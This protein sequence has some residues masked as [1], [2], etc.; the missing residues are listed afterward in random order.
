[1]ARKSRKTEIKEKQE[2]RLTSQKK[3][4]CL[5][6]AAYGRLS[7]YNSGHDT[8]DTIQNQTA[9]LVDYIENQPDLK[10]E[11]VYI[12]NGYS[13]TNFERPEFA[14]LMDDVRTGKIQCIVVKD[15]SR[16]GRNYLEMGYY[17]ETLLPR[18]NVRLIAITDDF[19]SSRA[20]DRESISVPIKNMVNAMYAKDLSRKVGTAAIMRRQNPDKLPNGTA[21]FGYLMNE[22]KTQYILHPEIAPYVR[23]IF[24]WYLLG[25]RPTEIAKRMTLLGVV[26]PVQYRDAQGN[27]ENLKPKKWD[28]SCVQHLLEQP[29]FVGDLFMGKFHAALYKNEAARKLPREEWTVRKN[30]HEPL[31]TRVDYE[32]VR[33]NRANHYSQIGKN[34]EVNQRERQ[35]L[36]P[37]LPAIVYCAECNRKMV[38]GRYMHDYASKEKAVTYY[39]CPRKN[40]KAKCGGH[41]VFNDFLKVVVMD[42]IRFMVQGVCNRK[43]LI[44]KISESGTG[45]NQLLSVQKQIVALEKKAEDAEEKLSSLYENYAEGLL[46]TEDYQFI[47]E[48]IILDRQGM[49][50]KLQEL[51]REERRWKNAVKKYVELA[52]NLEKYLDIKEFDPK[53]VQELISKIV[54]SKT[55]AIEIRFKFADVFQ[56]IDDLMEE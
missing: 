48:K 4:R 6:T 51:R 33:E 31:V 16:F 15:L 12:D 21:P 1:M 3:E 34:N 50:E 45:Q 47:K 26:T 13:G 2:N 17:I 28:C 54:V 14:R 19:D 11:D 9:L 10:L 7:N 41:I 30:T 52:G 5:A 49:E 53:L 27:I 18:L 55:G 35:R 37:E 38:F 42:Q 20:E 29:S 56:K 8:D 36:Q 46:E 25:D 44:E 32:K 39:E 23:M 43:K 24:Q 40:G 22:T